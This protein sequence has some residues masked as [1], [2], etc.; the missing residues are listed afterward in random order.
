MFLVRIVF[1][2]SNFPL[3]KEPTY[4]PAI[5]VMYISTSSVV[6]LLIVISNSLPVDFTLTLPNLIG[7][8]SAAILS[9]E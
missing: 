2:W 5:S 9:T 6:G 3:Y 1:W 8:G 7:S 4:F